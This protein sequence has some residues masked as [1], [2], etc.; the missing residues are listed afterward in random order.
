MSRIAVV[1]SILLVLV[2][3]GCSKV[4]E[5]EMQ[6]TQTAL[7]A[8]RSAEAELYAPEA[9]QTA[10][11]TLNAAMAAKQEQDSKFKLFRSYGDTKDLL[12]RA[13]VLADQAA[14]KAAVEKERIIRE[15]TDLIASAQMAVDNAN[16]ALAGAPVGKGSRAE[17]ELMKSDLGFAATALGEARADFDAGM[18][19][20]ARTRAQ[21]AIDKANAVSGEIEA[22]IARKAG[23]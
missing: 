22:A 13:K 9:Y 14:S 11:D 3:T 8:A 10:V 17:I 23:K 21:A 15:V 7:D 18:Y 20:A 6:A 2:F 19:E 16:A 12:I 4:P 5:I 1:L